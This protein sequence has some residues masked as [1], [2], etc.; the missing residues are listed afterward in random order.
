MNI[1]E[2]EVANLKLK[3]QLHICGGNKGTML[4]ILKASA[5]F[6]DPHAFQQSD[7]MLKVPQKYIDRYLELYPK[8]LESYVHKQL[9]KM[10]N[11][12]YITIG[13]SVTIDE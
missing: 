13:D 5:F 7:F 10:T 2:N 8:L 9:S 11:V 3:I 12:S 4:D 6:Y 1:D